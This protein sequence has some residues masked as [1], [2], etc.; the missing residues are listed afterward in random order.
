MAVAVFGSVSTGQA[1]STDPL[2]I[3]HTVGTGESNI[4]LCVGAHKFSDQAETISSVIW[5]PAGDN[6][7]LTENILQA[8][9][10]LQTGMYSKAGVTTGTSETLRI[11]LSAEENCGGGVINF[12]GVDQTTPVSNATQEN[13]ASGNPN[14]TVTTNA[15]ADDMVMDTVVKQTGASVNLA[16]DGSQTERW[17]MNQ[18]NQG[19]GGST[20]GGGSN[21][22]EMDWTHSAAVDLGWIA[23]GFLLNAAAAADTT[24][25]V[26]LETLALGEQT[27]TV[28]ETDRKAASI[29]LETLALGEIAPT[30]VRSPT[31]TQTAFRV[32]N[33]DGTQI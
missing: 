12:S 2:D 27:P 10:N 26:P 33:N 8:R 11:D 32:Y 19:G 30:V 3:T 21:P 7:T 31:Y 15:D 17:S 23:C 6:E 9:T 16:A 24:I 13:A 4:C 22:T 18:G 14:V 1:A 25:S 20:E 29:P 5:D 28:G